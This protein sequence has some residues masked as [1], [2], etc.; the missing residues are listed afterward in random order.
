MFIAVPATAV[1]AVVIVSVLFEVAF[2]Q[3]PFEA[4][5]V[6]VTVPAVL[7]AALGL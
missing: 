6:K 4:V 5:N 1:A 2:A 7:S 3:P